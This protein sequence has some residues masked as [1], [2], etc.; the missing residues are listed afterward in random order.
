MKSTTRLPHCSRRKAAR[1]AQAAPM[2]SPLPSRH[3]SPSKQDR[4]GGEAAL[5]PA[6]PF[7]TF[8][9]VNAANAVAVAAANPC[10]NPAAPSAP[11]VDAEAPVHSTLPASIATFPAADIMPSAALAPTAK[12]ATS[13]AVA[14]DVSVATAAAYSTLGVTIA[15]D[16]KMGDRTVKAVELGEKNPVVVQASAPL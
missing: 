6:V 4:K 11:A 2:Q 14:A 3:C 8:A 13:E 5:T 12:F 9:A 7:I 1:D 10:R 15:D 16:A